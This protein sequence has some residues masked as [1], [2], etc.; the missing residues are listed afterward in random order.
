[1]KSLKLFNFKIKKNASFYLLSI[2]SVPGKMESEYKYFKIVKETINT[3][4][5]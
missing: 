3:W 2:L 4:I 5:G 1:M